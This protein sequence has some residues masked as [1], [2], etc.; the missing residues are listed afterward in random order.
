MR[1][2]P[3][4]VGSPNFQ[5]GSQVVVREPAGEGGGALDRGV[6]GRVLSRLRQ[7]ARFFYTLLT[8]P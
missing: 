6:A 8:E 5:L 2:A 1:K 4:E 3:P 7:L